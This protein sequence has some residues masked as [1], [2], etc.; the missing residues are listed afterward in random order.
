M[1]EM[2]RLLKYYTEKELK[3]IF[4]VP[5]ISVILRRKSLTVAELNKLTRIWGPELRHIIDPEIAHAPEKYSFLT[6]PKLAHL[7]VSINPKVSMRVRNLETGRSKNFRGLPWVADTKEEVWDAI[8]DPLHRL[9][10]PKFMWGGHLDAIEWQDYMRQKPYYEKARDKLYTLIGKEL[11]EYIKSKSVPRP[12][13]PV[14]F[15]ETWEDFLK[16]I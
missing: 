10:N 12:A 13:P 14:V 9:E 6:D 7:R 1:R 2:E 4:N 11:T 15:P 16:K 5:Y 8:V 3:E